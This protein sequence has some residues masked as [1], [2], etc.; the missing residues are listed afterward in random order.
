ML[1]DCDANWYDL[2]FKYVQRSK[3]N[4]KRTHSPRVLIDGWEPPLPE[5]SLPFVEFGVLLWLLADERL[6]ALRL[7][8]WRV[9]NIR[10]WIVAGVNEGNWSHITLSKW[11]TGLSALIITASIIHIYKQNKVEINFSKYLLTFI[12][13]AGPQVPRAGIFSRVRVFVSGIFSG[14]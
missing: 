5:R 13:T 7:W 11:S 3:I 12:I 10:I 2:V 9:L 4:S 8:D 1:K 6:S 14:A